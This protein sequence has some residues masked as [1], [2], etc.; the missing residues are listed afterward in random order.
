MKKLLLILTVVFVS[1]TS[2]F[3]DN[4]ANAP[5][6]LNPYA[7]DLTSS[8]DVGTQTLTVN[9][10]LNAEPNL[11][12]DKNNSHPDHPRGIQLYAVDSQGN[13]YR[14]WGPSEQN[15][16]D[17]NL[18]YEDIKISLENGVDLD[19]KTIPAGVQLT[20]KVTVKGR[21]KNGR[22]DPT[23]IEV[24]SGFKHPWPAMG[25]DVNKD[26]NS[27][28]Y[29]KI[30]VTAA[31]DGSTKQNSST[32]K[33]LYD[34]LYDANYVASSGDHKRMPAVLEYT[35][36]LAYNTL[37]KKYTHIKENE[38]RYNDWFSS[39]IYYEPHRLRI[40]KDGR[41]F[42]T[43]YHP[44]ASAAVMELREDL[45]KNIFKTVIGF[46]NS[47][48]QV[49]N[50]NLR[51]RRVVSMDVRGE[52][53]DLTILLAWVKPEAW[54]SNNNP[55]AKI[56]VWEY[57]VG[58]QDKVLR[59]D[60]GKKV[61]EY[62]DH[63]AGVAVLG[64]IYQGYVFKTSDGIQYD[65]GRLGFIEVAYGEGNDIWMKVDFAM[66][67]DNGFQSRIMY[68][69]RTGDLTAKSTYV[70]PRGGVYNVAGGGYYGG[71]SLCVHGN[72]LITG[73]ANS[74][75][76]IF[77]IQGTTNNKSLS[78]NNLAVVTNIDNG[79][80]TNGLAIDPASNLYV[81]SEYTGKLTTVA[82]PYSGATTTPAPNKT[83]YTFML[84]G[85]PV[86][87]I[88]A[89]DLCVTPHDKQAKYIFS[90]NVNTKPEGAEI[91]FYT[92][93]Q[94]MLNDSKQNAA[95]GDYDNHDK[96][97]CYYRFSSTE[98]KQGRM[99]VEL[100]ILGHE[101]GKELVDKKL[102]AG[103]LYW[104]VFLKTR[105]SLAF[106]PIYVQPITDASGNR[107]HYRL[108][109]TIDNNPDNDGFGHIYAIDYRK[110]KTDS[111]MK[112]NPCWLMVY[113]IG[114]NVTDNTNRYSKIQH[115][116]ANDMVQ[117]RRP[118]V[119]PDGMVYLT[120]YGD[121][122]YSDFSTNLQKYTSEAFQM[123]GIWLFDPSL[124]A[125]KA[126]TGAAT[127]SRFY[128]NK[129]SE[130]TSGVSF[131]GSGS[132]TILYKSNTYEEISHHGQG[133]YSEDDWAC[134]GYRVYNVGNTDGTINHSA[135]ITD[136][137]LTA[138]PHLD[139]NG[140]FSVKATSDGVWLCQHR[141]IAE[142]AEAVS[143]LFCNKNGDVKFKSYGANTTNGQPLSNVLKY[144]PGGGMTVS[145]DE[146]YLYVVNYEGN[147]LEFEI[148][149]SATT[150]KTLTLKNKFINNTDHK[151]ISTMNFDYAGNLVVT[152]DESYPAGRKDDGSYEETQI[153]VFT[154]PYNRDNARSIPASKAQRE[155]PER[156]AYNDEKINTETTIAK[157]P[158]LV[159]L[160]RPMPNTS[161]STI[162]LP[163]AL[164]IST[165]EDGHPYKTADIRA[166]EGAELSAVGGEKILYLN[167][168][169]NPV[170]SLSANTPYIIQP[171]VRI[172]NLVQ[173]PATYWNTDAAPSGPYAFGNNNS[174]TFTGVIPKQE[175]EVQE[176]KT[177]L[178]VAENRLAEMV[179][180][181]TVGG[182]PVGEILGFRGYFTLGAPL[183][184]GMQ[185][186][187][188]NKDNTVTGLVDINGKKVNINKYLREGRV[189]IRVGD[190]LYT[191]D[192]QK[193]K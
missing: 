176:G 47:N 179:S 2:V 159:D 146:K 142:D 134:N 170:T 101:G 97:A 137:S 100:D 90:F 78:D 82:L 135:Q 141:T 19:G 185:A 130:T 140:S 85:D 21:D 149:E 50:D 190:S 42:V 150:G 187:L 143:V 38:T 81:V 53:D 28:N 125:N 124:A 33:W 52:D 29:G 46:D 180:D 91:R 132:S 107:T 127:L 37:H 75:L 188:R 115:L 173:L 1:V 104:N 145:P 193:V 163:F 45:G 64:L 77:T 122:R 102:P 105:E 49:A 55:R 165:L 5:Y 39:T 160:Y 171:S 95:Y 61:A 144:T 87:N 120:D 71:A 128:L 116:T 65:M 106:A 136:G 3:A 59:F 44:S 109:A 126:N 88:L 67:P 9:F 4:D 66:N 169:A 10:K 94:D 168:S 16:K 14:I 167:F 8:W 93:E 131:Y 113:S 147:I 184:K 79:A 15:I 164:D 162:C 191:V 30:Y 98:L 117:P 23:K 161:Y 89:T 70:T 56:E 103:K 157:K 158:A 96:C 18:N 152:T 118:A 155:I 62:W 41:V 63:L 54:Y 111:E 6:T 183:P 121:Y 35:P 80:W 73:T 92:S 148:G 108:H 68:F 11:D 186:I 114:E 58:N 138:L 40:S 25:I 175:I 172:P 139:A 119:A 51:N 151:T 154:M 60:E 181:K 27:P 36:R 72:Q 156:L 153:V 166:F 76:Q 32:H 13:S 110:D 189:Y 34:A 178:L 86:P 174:I 22:T 31:S 74:K 112:N 84:A 26:P 48:T 43:S 12:A 99:S 182:Q 69:N 17:K 123:G 133:H 57:E 20:W 129:A 177:L 192:G 7:Y 24:P 83:E